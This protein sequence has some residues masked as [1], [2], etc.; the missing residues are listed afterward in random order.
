LLIASA[1]AYYGKG[2]IL[3]PVG[4]TMVKGRRP[5]M[6]YSAGTTVLLHRA[7]MVEL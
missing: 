3:K 6:P 7:S 1:K 5:M 4:K 2:K